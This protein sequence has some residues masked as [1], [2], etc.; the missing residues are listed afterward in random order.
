M[1]KL[2]KDKKEKK[3][4]FRKRKEEF[5]SRL[6]EDDEKDSVEEMRIASQ[7]SIR[8][9][10]YFLNP[11]FQYGVEHGSDVYRETFEG[12]KKV[13]MKLER[14]MDDQIKALNSLV[15]FKDMG[16]TFATPQ[17]QRAWSRMNP[18][19]W[20]LMFGSCSPELQ[21]VAIKVLSQTTSATNCERNWSTF[22]YIHTKT[23]NRLKYKKLQKLVFTHY[24]MK[25]KMRHQMRKSQEEIESSFNP[26]NLDYIF[27]EDDPLSA[28]IEERENPLL[29]G[30]QNSEWL[31][32]IDTDDEDVEGGDS[33]NDG[34]DLS[35]PSNNSGDDGVDIEGE[36]N[37]GE[38]DEDEQRQND[39]YQETPY[40]R[41]DTNL[42]IDFTT[43]MPGMIPPDRS[44]SGDNRRDNSQVRRGKN[45]QNVSCQDSS[46]SHIEQSFSEFN[47]DDSSESSQ[48]YYPPL[49]YQHPYFNA[50]NQ[51]GSDQVPSYHQPS[52]NYNY[53]YY[54]QQSGGFF[55]YVFGQGAT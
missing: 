28:W 3:I 45:K 35:P 11:Q 27:R 44:F 48:G 30:V 19:E 12:T 7:Q 26:I 4:D 15:L 37:D 47:I 1:M 41:R 8:S 6:R 54:Q 46:S 20:W 38:D 16:E 43:S 49:V 50:Y 2:L 17:A 21:R 9:Q 29:D 22:S 53:L 52:M 14:N 36:E 33:D 5:E 23:R 25:L 18:A 55:Y 51:Y 32:R 34:G 39:P 24:N 13:I 42:V 31:P 40:N 10:R